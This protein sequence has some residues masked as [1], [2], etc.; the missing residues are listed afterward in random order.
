M[1]NAIEAA[2]EAIRE[3][4]RKK[5]LAKIDAWAKRMDGE[6]TEGFARF[7]TAME[8]REPRLE[9]VWP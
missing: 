9:K 5:R 6:V 4:R 3:N 1:T 2:L 8:H 7:A